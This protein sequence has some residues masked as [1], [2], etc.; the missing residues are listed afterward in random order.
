MDR[1]T[2]EGS[3][4]AFVELGSEEQVH[5]AVKALDGLRISKRPLR[6]SQ[7]ADTFEWDAEN[8][9]RSQYFVYD[10]AAASQA[11]QPLLEGRRY[12]V[13]VEKPGWI[14]ERKVAKSAMQQRREILDRMFQSFNVEAM[15][16]INPA[17]KFSKAVDMIWVTFVD[18]R[19]K[20]DAQR[21]L[22]TLDDSIIE[23]RRVE[24]RQYSTIHPRRAEHIGKVDKGVLARLQEAGFVNGNAG[25]SNL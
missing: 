1:F 23:G 4:A 14:S 6:V 11:I 16:G 18:F 8:R 20:E 19:T 9:M 7:L 3:S 21:A 15:G 13:F 17:W 25:S 10:A 12:T 5:R 2:F 22:N 24:L